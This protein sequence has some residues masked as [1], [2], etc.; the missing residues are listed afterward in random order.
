MESVF[1]LPVTSVSDYSGW[2]CDMGSQVQ[3][4]LLDCTAEQ[5]LI[6]GTGCS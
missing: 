3:S 2:A 4:F 6:Q 5:G 1:K